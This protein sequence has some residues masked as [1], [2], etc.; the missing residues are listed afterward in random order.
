MALMHLMATVEVGQYINLWKILPI[1][2]VLLIWARLMTWAD[3]DAID[4]HLPRTLLN[5]IMIVVLI[6]SLLTFLMVPAYLVAISVF[7]FAF[8]VDMGVYLGLRQQKVGL[9][10]LNKQ[11][12]DW[13]HSLTSG[14]AKEVK[15]AEGAV[16]LI[17]KKGNT[18]AAP[19]TDAPEAPGYAAAQKFLADPMRR[20]AEQIDLVPQE[21]AA[22]VR[23]LADGVP[24]NGT[25]LTRDEAAAAITYLKRLASLDLTELRK[26]QSGKMKL[27]YGGKKHEA[28]VKT[29][30]STAGESIALGIDVKTRH[31]RKLEEL[32]MTDDQF[33]AVLDVVQDATGIVLVS[34]PKGQGL[35]SMLYAILK[36]HDAFL[37]HIQTIERNPP[38]ELE[39]IKQNKL[40]AVSTPG[41]EAKLVDW[42][43]SQEPDV[44]GIAEMED[45]KSAAVALR[46]AAQ[47][48]R[49]YV[50]LRA[51]NTFEALA[52]WRKLVGDDAEAMK[53]LKFII[54]GRVVRKLC[55]ACKVGYTADPDTLRKWNMS[56]D[57]VGKLYQARTQPLRDPK[58]N[59]L[60]CEFCQDMHFVGRVGVFETFIVDD[61]VR[62]VIAAGGSV[63]QLKALFRKQRQ[64]LLQE[65]ALGRVESG[66]TSVQEVARVLGA[67]SGSKPAAGSPP[68]SGGGGPSAGG[69]RRPSS[70]PKPPR[71][72]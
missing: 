23:F 18:I 11:F 31:G 59:P 55:M 39:G 44:V 49:L 15:V 21:G 46:Y 48:K 60:I 7:L 45:P 30:G 32:G 29:A 35:T 47:G 68:S 40:P 4:A 57:K 63:N 36:K 58:G 62:S 42:V 37:T 16:G 26:P 28:E 3:K 33:T 25:S 8:I 27:S 53:D 34:A 13:L 19:D 38:V 43:C 41:E 66:D 71:K 67:S 24:F 64:K 17:D 5:S 12:K 56:P 72:P 52:Q 65:S 54:N 51:T 10:D 14:K 9:K 61:E 70:S 6:A 50:G 2:V 22:A 20:H 1:L 69:A